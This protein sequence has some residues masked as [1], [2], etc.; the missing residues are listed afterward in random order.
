MTPEGGGPEPS[1]VP[2][3]L[4]LT[5]GQRY[6]I[7][8]PGLGTAGYRWSHQPAEVGPVAELSWQH[9]FPAGRPGSRPVGV[10]APERVTITGL[11]PGRTTVRLVL[12]R[13]W[14]SAEPRAVHVV[15]IEVRA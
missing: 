13:P 5:V 9:G 1:P 2:E 15:E 14:E 8:L 7:A 4:V 12:S 11:A 3:R 6:E 10:S